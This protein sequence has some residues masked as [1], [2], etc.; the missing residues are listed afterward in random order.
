MHRT[1]MGKT[2][3]RLNFTDGQRS[4]IITVAVTEDSGFEGL[5]VFR[6][7]RVPPPVF[8]LSGSKAHR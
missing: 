5:E 3:G 4:G 6:P 1:A 7:L 2:T 8:L